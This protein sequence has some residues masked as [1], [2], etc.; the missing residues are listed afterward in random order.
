MPRCSARDGKV[1]FG[2]HQ[3]AQQIRLSQHGGTNKL[4]TAVGNRDNSLGGAAG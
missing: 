2:E 4:G 3:L 1:M